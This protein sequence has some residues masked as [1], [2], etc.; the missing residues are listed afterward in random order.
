MD[1]SGGH[2]SLWR[3]NKQKHLSLC[4][5]ERGKRW[6]LS[7]VSRMLAPASIVFCSPHSESPTPSR[8]TPDMNKKDSFSTAEEIK[9]PTSKVSSCLLHQIRVRTGGHKH[10]TGS[11]EATGAK[12]LMFQ[13][14]RFLYVNP[15]QRKHDGRTGLLDWTSRSTVELPDSWTESQIRWFEPS[16]SAGGANTTK[17][18]PTKT[19]PQ[20]NRNKGREIKNQ[21]LKTTTELRKQK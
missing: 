10:L 19:E 17:Q 6:R 3:S 7:G 8:K 21:T 4:V 16:T 11:S 20:A 15:E 13:V 5:L 9:R 14:K 12:T 2:V 18:I 1:A